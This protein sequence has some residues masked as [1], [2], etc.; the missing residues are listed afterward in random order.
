MGSDLPSRVPAPPRP[1]SAPSAPA[2]PCVAT[3]ADPT[4]N[5][6]RSLRGAGAARCV[7]DL[8]ALENDVPSSPYAWKMLFAFIDESY[9]DERYYIGALL[10]SVDDIGEL[11][12]A[13]HAASDYAAGFGV[14]IETEFHGHRIMT[15]RDGWEAVRGKARAAGMIYRRALQ[16]IAQLRARLYI[17]GVDIARLNARYRYPDPPHLVALRHVLEDVNSAAT[18]LGEEVIVICDNVTDSDAHQ[19]RFGQYQKAGTP[20]FRSS[21]L[22]R[23]EQFMFADSASSPGLQAIDLA[24][25]LHRR[26]DAHATGSDKARA[27]ALSLWEELRPI[28]AKARRWDP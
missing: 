21:K 15:G 27:L 13:L 10:V 6:R 11:A 1:H 14:P 18:M 9:T 25:Y 23:I 26:I 16:Q 22:G 8:Y 20:G 3:S 17:E 7:R 2:H 5:S 4:A 24:I 28:V 12:Q 19:R